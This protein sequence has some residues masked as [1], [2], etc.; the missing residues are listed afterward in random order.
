M[1]DLHRYNPVLVVFFSTLACIATINAVGRAILGETPILSS[2]IVT[3]LPATGAAAFTAYAVRHSNSHP[4]QPVNLVLGQSTA[5]AD[6]DTK[7]LESLSRGTVSWYTISGTNS[8]FM[9]MEY[10]LRPLFHSSL[11]PKLCV[12]VID[13]TYLGGN[14]AVRTMPDGK[15]VVNTSLWHETRAPWLVSNQYYMNGL[16][17]IA[18]DSIREKAR[19]AT[20]ITV[21][22]AYRQPTDDEEKEW[23]LVGKAN[24]FYLANQIRGY[25]AL[26]S[27]TEEIY[28]DDGE[29]ASALIRVIDSCRN[30]GSKVAIVIQPT[31]RELA[32]RVPPSAMVKLRRVLAKAREHGQLTIYDMYAPAPDASM[33]DYAHLNDI[34][35]KEFTA[36]LGRKL[37]DTFGPDLSN[38]H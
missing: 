30:M 2:E 23:N 17:Q 1:L 21:D 25:E 14:P 24:D 29:Q 35:K 20:G 12:L 36:E 37:I 6:I 19:E 11:L 9:K 8:S 3:G 16:V 27:F 18:S 13:P 22:V 34:G 5:A 38:P 28:H 7:A 33:H 32:T 4:R 31:S 26:G 15:R 10:A